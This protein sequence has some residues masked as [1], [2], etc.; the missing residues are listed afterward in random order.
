MMPFVNVYIH[1]VFSTKQRF[2]FLDT[3]DLRNKIWEHIKTNAKDKGVLVDEIGGYKDHC[4]CLVALNVNQTISNV[5][6]LIKGESSY[7]INK[8]CLTKSK[9]KWQAEYYAASVSKSKLKK[10]RNY[11]R[12]QEAHHQKNDQ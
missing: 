9:F 12:N 2:P 5:M 1:F 3:I 6:Q 7:W 10:V 8:N 11:I 4:H